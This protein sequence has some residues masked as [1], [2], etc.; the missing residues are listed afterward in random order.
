MENEM[1]FNVGP[2]PRA[3][4][5]EAEGARERLGKGKI[6]FCFL[7][8]LG[9]WTIFC[10]LGTWIF[11]YRHHFFFTEEAIFL[12]YVYTFCWALLIWVI[13]A[14]AFLLL[15]LIFSK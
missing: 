4:V 1:S 2:A 10:F 3:E 7:I 9:M 14:I 15:Y 11:I 12:T 8:S 13:P 6:S 5:P